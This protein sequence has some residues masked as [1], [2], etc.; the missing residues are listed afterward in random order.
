MT[1]PLTETVDIYK[2]NAAIL[3]NLNVVPAAY[4]L[5][6]AGAKCNIHRGT[7]ESQD[8]VMALGLNQGQSGYAFFAVSEKDNLGDRYILLDEQS[9]A[10]LI[11]V[12]PVVRNRFP[13]TAH[14]KCLVT[15]LTVKPGGIP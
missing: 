14:V 4:T 2:H 15:L 5:Q 10:W 11:R 12:V 6:K 13:Q 7:P 1:M 3:A 8:E 9:D